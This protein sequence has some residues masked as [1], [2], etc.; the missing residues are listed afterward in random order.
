MTTL[1]DLLGARPDDDAESLRNAFRKAAKANHPDLHGGDPDASSRFKQIVAAYDVLRH[2]EQRAT[3]DQLLEFERKQLRSKS[4]RAISYFISDAVAA[5]GLASVLAGGYTV[6]THNPK[7][8]I[9]A[10]EVAAVTAPGA[11]KIVG[12]QS[13]ARTG[14]IEPDET[15]SKLER[16]AV[17]DM[18]IVLSGVA[19]GASN[20]GARELANGPPAPSSPGLNAE[21][22]K[23]NK[24]FGASIDQ[25][26]AKTV[27]NHLEKNLALEPLG[28]HKAQ[29]VEAQ[30]SSTEKD[31]GVPKSALSDF[32]MSKVKGDMK[33]SD[34]SDVNI[35]D[36]KTSDTPNVSTGD[37]KIPEMKIPGRSRTA[38]KRQ[39]A[40]RTPFKQASLENRNAPAC[41]G[42]QSCSADIPPLFGVGF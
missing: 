26:E 16:V 30:F 7:A 11:T 8:P 20:G 41:P 34:S 5:V 22:A 37:M 31:N 38:A 9:E 40:S 19:S 36:M 27:A 18:P 3:Y 23:I 25:G 6:F 21:V 12:V 15:H 42:S 1:Y 14:T 28:Q 17:P 2:A 32:A 10:S 13:A 39:P 24:A 35:G 33:T 29:S 4:K